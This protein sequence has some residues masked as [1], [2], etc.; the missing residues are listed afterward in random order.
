[1][2]HRAQIKYDNKKKSSGQVR[3]SV[4]VPE[5][6]REELIEIAKKLRGE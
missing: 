5:N 4:W 6:K 2:E 3:V 1:M